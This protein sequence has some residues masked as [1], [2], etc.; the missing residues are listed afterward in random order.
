MANYIYKNNYESTRSFEVS[1]QFQPLIQFTRPNKR[2]FHSFCF[3]LCFL[4]SLLPAT[5][6]VLSNPLNLGK[7]FLLDLSFDY[8]KFMLFQV[9]LK[10]RSL[11]IAFGALEEVFWCLDGSKNP[12]DLR[13]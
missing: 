3:S 5:K 6:Q 1:M 13:L 4:F 9:I 2:K 12:K 8:S 7:H 11:E 10:D